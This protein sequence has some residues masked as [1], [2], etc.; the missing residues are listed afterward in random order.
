[1]WNSTTWKPC[2]HGFILRIRKNTEKIHDIRFNNETNIIKN[3]EILWAVY[4]KLACK[5]I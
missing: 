3:V 4:S 5:E 2:N 1:M